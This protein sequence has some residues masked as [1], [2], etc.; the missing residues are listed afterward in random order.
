MGTPP[1]P[2]GILQ[3]TSFF[4]FLYALETT[5]IRHTLR[6]L[7]RP[8][9][10][11]PTTYP[12]TEALGP[13]A[14]PLP[15]QANPSLT[16][17]GIKALGQFPVHQ[18]GQLL[19][20]ILQKTP[21]FFFL[22]A[23]ETTRIRH[24]LRNL[25]RPCGVPLPP[26]PPAN[27]SPWTPPANPDPFPWN[28][29]PWSTPPSTRPAPVIT[30]PPQGIF[31]KTPFFFFCTRQKYDTRCEICSTPPFLEPRPLVYPPVR[32]RNDKNTTHIAKFAPSLDRAPT[33]YPPGTEALNIPSLAANPSLTPSPGIK[34]LGLPP[35]PPGQLRWVPP[36]TPQGILQKTPFS[37][38]LYALEPTKT[39]HTLRN[40]LR[41][42]AR[43]PTTYPPQNRSPWTSPEPL[44]RQAPFFFFLYALETTKKRHTLRNLLRPWGPCRYHLPPGTEALGQANP[45]LTPCPF[46]L[47]PTLSW[48]QGYP[49]TT[50]QGIFQKT[51]FFFFLY[52]FETAKIHTRCEICSVPGVRALITYPPEPKPAIAATHVAKAPVPLPPTP[53][54]PKPLDPPPPPSPCLIKPTLPS[55]LY[56]EPRLLVYPPST[57]PP[58][59][60]FSVPQSPWT[61]PPFPAF[62][63]TPTPPTLSWNQGPW[64]TPPSTRPAPVGSPPPYRTSKTTFFRFWHPQPSQSFSDP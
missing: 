25:L 63:E 50:P 56:L 44:P 37:F 24:P 51:P 62:Q 28:Q 1:T 3:K 43:A 54:E 52:A 5:K 29:G 2:Q 30:P 47:P 10:P 42:W 31:Q 21:F 59:E 60:I 53:P 46:Q 6:N 33:T 57:K 17:S 9:G 35:R 26:P 19:Q 45:S 34:A 40:L 39:R 18:P 58:C 12:G 36:P 23:L 64:S 38:F 27:R 7:L 41:P 20:G 4:F 15:R 14:E 32:V 22:Y 48:N 11:C 61:P 49:P 8:W 55:P 16:F 13:P